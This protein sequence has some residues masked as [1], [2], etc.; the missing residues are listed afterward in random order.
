[1]KSGSSD[2]HVQVALD[3]EDKTNKGAPSKST[4]LGDQISLLLYAF[5]IYGQLCARCVCE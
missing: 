1:M 3:E 4:G 5:A 2:T